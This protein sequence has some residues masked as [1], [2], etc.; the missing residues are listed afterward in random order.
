[1]ILDH[2]FVDDAL[3]G[4]GAGQQLVTGAVEWAHAET[5]RLLPLC[6]YARVV[7]DKTPQF[8]DVRAL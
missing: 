7:F 8:A 3:R 4:T 6:P 5:R 1:V 2:T